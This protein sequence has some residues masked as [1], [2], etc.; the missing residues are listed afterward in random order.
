MSRTI[1]AARVATL[2]GTLDRTPRCTSSSP[3]ALG[4]SSARAGSPRPPGCPA[5]AS[6]PRR[7]ASAGPRSPGR[8]PSCASGTTP[9][10]GA[11]PAP[12]PGCRCA[13]SRS[14][15]GPCPVAG[16]P[17][18]H[19]PQLRG[20][21]RPAR[22]RGGVRAGGRRAAGLPLQPRLLPGRAPR[23]PGGRRG[24]VRRA[25][26][27]H[28]PEQ[29]IITAGALPAA[30][31]VAQALTA[32]GDRVVVEAPVYPNA[33]QAL[34][35]RSARLVAAPVDPGGWDI[36]GHGRDHPPGRAPARLPGAGLPEPDGQPDERRAAGGVRRRAASRPGGPG[37]RRGPPGPGPRRA[38]DAAR[39]SRRTCPGR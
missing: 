11:A 16:G 23:A 22:R 18:R 1:T 17:R 26:T 29:I 31:I 13:P 12:S 25:G 38:G 4:C 8:T 21:E 20:T 28:H 35:H 33:T 2:V 39:R 7:W 15:T 9:S 30:V 19:R 27:A 24:D 34:S 6:S 14:P 5:S 32:P 36:A 10:R 37:R 3:S